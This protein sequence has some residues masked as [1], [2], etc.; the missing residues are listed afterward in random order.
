M[1]NG[2][3]AGAGLRLFPELGDFFVKVSGGLSSITRN[4]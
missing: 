3:P 4:V 2:T 1:G